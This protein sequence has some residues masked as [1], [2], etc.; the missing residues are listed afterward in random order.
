VRRRKHRVKAKLNRSVQLAP[1]LAKGS[2]DPMSAAH[3]DR[4]PRSNPK[5]R[6]ILDAAAEL[7]LAQGYAAI[8]MDAVA[9]QA[10]VSKATLYAYFPGKQ[11]LFRTMVEIQCERMAT[12]ATAGAGHGDALRPALE[13]LGTAVLRFLIAPATLAIHRIMQAEMAREPTLAE[14][15]YAA[16]PARVR[17]R[18]ADWIAE[19]QRLGRIRA[20]AD[21]ARAA[22]DFS[23]LLRSDL[24]TRA[25]FGLVPQPQEAEIAAEAAAAADVFLRA[26]GKVSE[27]APA[28]AP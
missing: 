25:L 26:Y 23:A 13:R 7:F 17:A 9:R 12:E 4:E 16:G 14:I 18:L 3:L 8:S 11:A 28:P 5:L 2:Y 1:G 21:P 19:E 27:G 15:F 20:E 10:G 22:I 6:A 24:W